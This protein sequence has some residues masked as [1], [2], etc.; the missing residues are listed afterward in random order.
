MFLWVKRNEMIRLIR[1]DRPYGTLLLLFPTLWSLF[2]ASFGHPT[3]HHLAVFILGSFFMRSAGCVMNDMADYKFDAKVMRTQNR[4]LAQ[5]SVTHK[6]AFVVLFFFLAVSLFLVLTL[7]KLTIALSFS[8]FFFATL[9]PFAKRFTH[10][11]QALL[12]ITFSFGIL[13]AWTA[14]HGALSVTPFLILLANLFWALGYD[15]IYAL[16][17]KE[18]DLKIGVK[19]M[20]ILIGSKPWRAIGLFFSLVIVFLLL[21]G[22]QNQMGTIY[23]LSLMLTAAIFSYQALMLKKTLARENLFPLFKAHVY[24]GGLILAGIVLQFYLRG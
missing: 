11:A 19:S 13:M 21:V 8:A 1:F 22:H 23:Y 5:G 17:D 9:Y 4:P 14:A 12:G 6:E 15:T 3:L 2:L 18:D 7:N 16:M 24:V 10:F 20:A